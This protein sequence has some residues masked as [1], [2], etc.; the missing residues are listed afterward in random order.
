MKVFVIIPAAGFGTR[1]APVSGAKDAKDKK[2]HPSKQF[3]ELKGTPILIH[4]LR[5][6]A[7]I[8]SVSEILMALRE[9][10]IE[11]FRDRLTKEAPDVL[12]KKVEF[13]IG[14]EHRCPR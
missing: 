3:T 13:V 12:Q 4:T 14:G 7:A 9:N 8:E 1:M 11:S 10:E 6:F 5:K 2:P